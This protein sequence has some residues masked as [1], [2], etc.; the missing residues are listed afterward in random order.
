MSG[1]MCY[2]R[3]RLA[4]LGSNGLSRAAFCRRRRM[5]VAIKLTEAATN[6]R[7]GNPRCLSNNAY[8]ASSDCSGFRRRPHAPRSLVWCGQ[9]N[10]RFIL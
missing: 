2:W 1:R 4:D 8:A 3:E 9:E 6:R 7:C 5:L 10:L